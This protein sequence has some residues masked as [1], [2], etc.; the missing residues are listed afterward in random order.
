MIDSRDLD[1]DLDSED[2]ST[3]LAKSHYVIPLWHVISPIAVEVILISNY[4]IRCTFF[5]T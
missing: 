1:M 3:S 2:L 5:T 4:Y